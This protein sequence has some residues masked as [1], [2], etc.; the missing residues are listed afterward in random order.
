MQQKISRHVKGLRVSK[1]KNVYREC[2]VLAEAPNG[3]IFFIPVTELDEVDQL[4]MRNILD[5]PTTDSQHLWE[6][7]A[8]YTLLN[9]VN[10]LEY[11]NQLTKILTADG[12]VLAFTSGYRGGP[13]RKQETAQKATTK[14]A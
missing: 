14:K 9:G 11:F 2:V 13:R 10:A 7:M 12:D 1:E 6:A 8:S 5:Q 4:R 3:D